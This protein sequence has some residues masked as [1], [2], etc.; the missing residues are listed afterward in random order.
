MPRPPPP[1]D[2]IQKL[3]LPACAMEVSQGTAPS[4]LA[5][6]AVLANLVT[7][8]QHLRGELEAFPGLVDTL[9]LGDQA[10]ALL[11]ARPGA[12]AAAL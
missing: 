5:Q 2:K 12:G 6:V 11:A 3:A 4:L 8:L 7:P 10:C 9:K 1:Y